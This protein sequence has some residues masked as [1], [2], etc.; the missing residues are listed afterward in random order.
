MAKV[1]K[2]LTAHLVDNNV[3]KDTVLLRSV[4]TGKQYMFDTYLHELKSKKIYG[5]C[6]THEGKNYAVYSDK[7]LYGLM[8]K[9]E[10]VECEVN[11]I[12]MDAL[13]LLG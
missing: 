6:V 3:L 13:K 10:V 12:P 8:K 9:L 2:K 5:L 1:M 11:V 7:E 4:K